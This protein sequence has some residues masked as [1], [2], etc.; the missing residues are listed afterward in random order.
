V[1]HH[2]LDRIRRW[3]WRDGVLCDSELTYVEFH[4]ESYAHHLLRKVSVGN[5]KESLVVPGR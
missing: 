1:A 4:S 3:Y 5:R 2:R